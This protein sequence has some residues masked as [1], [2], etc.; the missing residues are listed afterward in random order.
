MEA[1]RYF[2]RAIALRP[3]SFAAHE[4]LAN[5]LMDQRKFDDAIAEFRVAIKL[6][7]EN[8]DT[9]HNLAEALLRA[10]ENA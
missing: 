7:P 3:L 2:S 6:S 1:A 9:Y 5:A 10:G 4:N 8:P